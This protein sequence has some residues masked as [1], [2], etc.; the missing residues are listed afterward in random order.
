MNDR[1]AVQKPTISVKEAAEMLG[2]SV[3]LAYRMVREDEFP[4]RVLKIAT[5][6]RVPRAELKRY[7]NGDESAVSIRA[8][9]HPVQ[10]VAPAQNQGEAMSAPVRAVEVD[11]GS[12]LMR[13]LACTS[14]GVLLWDV[15][16]HWRHSHTDNEGDNDE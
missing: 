12:P 10:R 2:I 15:E 1:S 7:I 5:V 4:V 9:A 3:A 13:F 8:D 16:A 11:T 14:C 6:Y